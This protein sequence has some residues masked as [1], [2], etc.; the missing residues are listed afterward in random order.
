MFILKFSNIKDGKNK[1][2]LLVSYRVKKVNMPLTCFAVCDK[3]IEKK[4]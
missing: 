3:T 1:S 4:R 2:S